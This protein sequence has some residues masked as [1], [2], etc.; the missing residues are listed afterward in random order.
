MNW[1]IPFTLKLLELLEISAGG[2]VAKPFM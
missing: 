2:N 1:V